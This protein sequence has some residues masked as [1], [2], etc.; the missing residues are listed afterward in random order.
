LRDTF[1]CTDGIH[2]GEVCLT[3]LAFCEDL[4]EFVRDPVLHGQGAH[5]YQDRT[6]M[7]R[8]AKTCEI[9]LLEELTPLTGNWLM[10]K[11]IPPLEGE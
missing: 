5:L 3:N 1:I 6:S 2:I 7:P 9:L 4:L 11:P 8:V 10:V